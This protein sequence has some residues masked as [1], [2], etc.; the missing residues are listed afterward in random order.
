MRDLYR[1]VNT[2]VAL[3][4]VACVVA[5]SLFFWHTKSLFLT[6]FGLLQIILALP[7]SWSLYRFLFWLKRLV[8]KLFKHVHKFYGLTHISIFSFPVMN[9]GGIFVSQSLY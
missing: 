2:D 3:T 8:V 9:L 4:S 1:A 6:L 7:I 5:G